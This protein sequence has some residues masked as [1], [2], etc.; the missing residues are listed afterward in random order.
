MYAICTAESSLYSEEN[1]SDLA[2]YSNNF[3]GISTSS[4]WGSY[5][6]KE[7]G[8]LELAFILDNY[9]RNGLDISNFET[10]RN[11][12]APLEDGNANWLGNVSAAYS[13]GQEEMGSI[14]R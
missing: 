11:I 8:M 2:R 14:S 10:I 12:Y 3:S 5:A 1:R 7:E 6:T 4:G 13:T 9:R